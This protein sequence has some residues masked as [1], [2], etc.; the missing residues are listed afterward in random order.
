MKVPRISIKINADVYRFEPLP[1]I[2]ANELAMIM[3]FLFNVNGGVL[4]NSMWAEIGPGARRH[5]GI[6]LEAEPETPKKE[7]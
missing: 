4:T 7:G 5:F 6:E 3:A 2:T 1:D